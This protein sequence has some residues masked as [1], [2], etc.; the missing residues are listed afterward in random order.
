MMKLKISVYQ[1]AEEKYIEK[2]VLAKYKFTDEDARISLI[3]EIIYDCGEYDDKLGLIRIVDDNKEDYLL[4]ADNFE[5][6]ENFRKAHCGTSFMNDKY[7]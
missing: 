6:V 2:D 4:K 5:L 3:K 1:S 7:I